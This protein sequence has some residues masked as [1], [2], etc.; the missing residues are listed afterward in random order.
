MSGRAGFALLAGACWPHRAPGERHSSG[1]PSATMWENPYVP[2]STGSTRPPGTFSRSSGVP[3]RP[4]RM[5]FPRAIARSVVLVHRRTPRHAPLRALKARVWPTGGFAPRANRRRDVYAG[6]AT[7]D[8]GGVAAGTAARRLISAR[9][10]SN[11]CADLRATR[12]APP[13]KANVKTPPWC[14]A[15]HTAMPTSTPTMTARTRRRDLIL[16]SSVASSSI[17]RVE[18]SVADGMPRVSVG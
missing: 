7:S 1:A 3:R 17:V 18:K 5:R 12:M 4:S 15:D 10:R 6:H 16:V 11:G 2:G 13:S 8:D 14:V 9:T